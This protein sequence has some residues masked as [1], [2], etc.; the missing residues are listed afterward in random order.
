MGVA[1]LNS[2]SVALPLLAQRLAGGSSSG[3]S[4]YVGSLAG[5]LT[6]A[7]LGGLV[8]GVTRHTRPAARRPAKRPP[9]LTPALRAPPG[10]GVPS[11]Q[12]LVSQKVT[13]GVYKGVTTSELDELAAETAASLTATHP[14]YALVRRHSCCCGCCCCLHLGCDF[15]AERSTLAG[16]MF[17]GAAWVA[18]WLVAGGLPAATLPTRAPCP[19]FAAGRPHRGLQPAQEHAQVVQRDVRQLCRLA[20]CHVA[21]LCLQRR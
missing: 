2:S 20:S 8:S 17:Y 21:V 4:C 19:P 14:D 10:L 13:T 18:E 6:A 15:L 7:S 1:G 16:P 9:C 11:L 3:G 5:S 12:V